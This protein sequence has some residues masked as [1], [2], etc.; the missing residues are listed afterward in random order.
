MATI[1]ERPAQAQKL[2]EGIESVLGMLRTQALMYARLESFA[3]QQRRLVSAEDAAPLLAVLADR[4][5][6]AAELAPLGAALTPI[7]RHWELYRGGL[8]APEREEADRLVA[9][10]AACLQR[11]IESDEH[12]ARLL[13]ARRTLTMRELQSTRTGGS[14]MAAYRPVAE[15]EMARR[16]RLDEAT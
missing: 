2:S 14:A 11:V 16:G 3:R 1:A 6:L 7:R 5:R 9:E 12:D 13:S 8:T 15:A 4:Q 10:T